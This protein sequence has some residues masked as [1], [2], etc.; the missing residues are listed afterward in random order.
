MR[1]TG[2]WSARVYTAFRACATMLKLF[3][4]LAYSIV[5]REV[6]RAPQAKKIGVA[7]SFREAAAPP[8]LAEDQCSVIPVVI[9]DA[10]VTY[11][12]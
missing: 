3:S 1:R 10:A 11:Q 4:E 9:M 2:P 6:G 5:C 8:C 12:G 7:A